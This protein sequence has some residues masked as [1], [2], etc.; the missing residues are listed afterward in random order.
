MQLLF[1]AF[2]CINPLTPNDLH[3]HRAVSPLNSR[4]TYIYVANSVSKFGGI[5]LT[6]NLL[7]A[8]ACHAARPLKLR[9]SCRSQNVP[10]HLLNPS[11]NTDIYIDSS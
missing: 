8:V 7:T 2:Y 11:T 10:L 1:S 9:L 6:P 5:L 4:T 3:I